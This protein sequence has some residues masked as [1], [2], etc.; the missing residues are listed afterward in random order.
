[1]S[2]L[3]QNQCTSPRNAKCICKI[4]IIIIIIILINII[5]LYSNFLFLLFPFLFCR[6]IRVYGVHNTVNKVFHL[7][8]FECLYSNT[9]CELGADGVIGKFL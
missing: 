9:T 1:M 7:V 2:H 6:Y 3:F 8:H 4:V 5:I